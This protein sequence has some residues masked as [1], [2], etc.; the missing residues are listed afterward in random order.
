VGAPTVYDI[1]T[2]MAVISWWAY[3]G[4]V[5]CAVDYA[6]APNDPS[7]Q[8]GGGRATSSNGN[9]QSVNLTG[10]TTQTTYTYRVLCPVQQPTGSF[11]TQ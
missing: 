7:T 8:S 6:V 2:S 9:S 4:S 5:A 10:L 1:G 3:D 11:L